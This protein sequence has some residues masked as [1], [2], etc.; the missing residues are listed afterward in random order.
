MSRFAALGVVAVSLSLVGCYP[1]S[2][3]APGP[4]AAATLEIAKMKWADSTPEAMEQG[5]QTYIKACG[6][7]H[8]HP[9]VVAFP[10]DKWPA[11]AKV[12]GAKANLSP[13]DTEQMT[14]FVLAL[15]ASLTRP[16]AA[17]TAPAATP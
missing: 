9:D 2:A 4:L 11:E 15:R 5:R 12:M 16:A 8:G 7:C 13:A 17:T 3:A 1:K 6:E 14:R 10:E